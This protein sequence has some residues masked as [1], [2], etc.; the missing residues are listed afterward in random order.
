VRMGGP[1]E[2]VAATRQTLGVCVDELC[3]RLVA[4][5]TTRPSVPSTRCG[6]AVGGSGGSGG[7]GGGSGNGGGGNASEKCRMIN[8]PILTHVDPNG[9]KRPVRT[10]HKEL[11]TLGRGLLLSPEWFDRSPMLLYLGGRLRLWGPSSVV[12]L[13]SSSGTTSSPH[14]L[15]E[16]FWGIDGTVRPPSSTE[17]RT[18]GSLQPSA[19]STPSLAHLAT[20]Y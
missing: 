19:V 15:E 9:K 7:G 18:A 12:S 8:M 5:D 20:V 1:Y 10:E 6:G 4:V 2:L 14:Q 17:K 11:L 16:T 3:E 13:N